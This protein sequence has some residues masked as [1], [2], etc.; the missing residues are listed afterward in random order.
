MMFRG[1]EEHKR[2]TLN[3][4]KNETMRR[5]TDSTVANKRKLI[6]ANGRRNQDDLGTVYARTKVRDA[7]REG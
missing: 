2:G 6:T 4:F 1:L 3:V 5:V 7:G